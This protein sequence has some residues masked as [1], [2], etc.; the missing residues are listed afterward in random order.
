MLSR[1]EEIHNK[2]LDILQKAIHPPCETNVL[3]MMEHLDLNASET[4][5]VKEI[6]PPFF[7]STSGIFE[8]IKTT[9]GNFPLDSL[10]LIMEY[11]GKDKVDIYYG[12]FRVQGNQIKKLAA[13]GGAEVF[14]YKL[15]KFEQFGANPMESMLQVLC[16]DFAVF[17]N[18]DLVYAKGKGESGVDINEIW[19]LISKFEI[20]EEQQEKLKIWKTFVS[21]FKNPSLPKVPYNVWLSDD[22]E[23]CLAICH[24]AAKLNRVPVK[25]VA[26]RNRSN[27][28]IFITGNNNN[29]WEHQ[30]NE[31]IEV[32][33]GPISIEVSKF[34]WLAVSRFQK[35]WNPD[36]DLSKLDNLL[37]EMFKNITGRW[38]N[39]LLKTAQIEGVNPFKK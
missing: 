4:N 36:A 10:M 18:E 19:R 21:G 6:L 13:Q 24:E 17:Y 33:L 39:Y 25:D 29:L 20:S 28:K 11:K 14:S 35:Y 3:R 32:D 1:K 5:Y 15:R 37:N 7:G 26:L 22:R 16:L 8:A 38:T 12:N 2:V 23:E 31:T 9:V 34:E 27:K 30:R